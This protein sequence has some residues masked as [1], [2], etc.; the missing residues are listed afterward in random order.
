[1]DPPKTSSPDLK[2]AKALQ[3]AGAVWV[4]SCLVLF[5]LGMLVNGWLF[6]LDALTEDWLVDLAAATRIEYNLVRF[7][8]LAPG[9][10]LAALG[11]GLRRRASSK[12][13][14]HH[15]RANDLPEKAPVKG[16]KQ[17]KSV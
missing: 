11:Y 6:D 12:S 9:F 10:I 1:M 16:L 14:R 5:I 15:S 8:V 13:K 3:V 4:F 2:L 7:G 17:E